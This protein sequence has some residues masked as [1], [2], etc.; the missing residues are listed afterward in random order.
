MPHIGTYRRALPVN[1][2]RLYE[3]AIDWEHLPYIHRSSFARIECLDA[4]AWGFRARAWSQPYDERRAFVIELKLDRDCRRWITSTLEGPGQGSEVWTH[5]FPVADRETYIVVDFFV[6]NLAPQRAPEVFEFYKNLYTRLYDEDVAMMSERQ[7]QLD[8][9]KNRATIESSQRVLGSLDEVRLKLP[10]TIE[11]RGRRFRIVE[12]NG[13]LLAHSTVCPHTLGPL[14]T[15]IVANGIIECPWHGFR[16]D[17][18]TGA[19]VSG[20]N[21]KLPAAPTISVDALNL[22][23]IDVGTS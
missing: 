18:A 3:N 10:M 4:G 2:E 5:A 14:G 19:C 15:S 22:V 20:H 9:N 11:E 13:K 1:V 8:A 21:C 16:F 12:V 6:P 17:V 7:S 23:R